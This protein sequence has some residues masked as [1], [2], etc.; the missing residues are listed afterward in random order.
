MGTKGEKTKHFI[1]EAAFRL[2]AEKGFKDVTM[3]DICEKTGLSRGGLYR[4]YD[5]TSQIFLELIHTLMADQQNEFEEK[6]KAKVPAREILLH[7]LDRYETEML[8]REHSLSIAIYEFF[9]GPSVSKSSNSIQQQYEA[10]KEMWTALIRYGIQTG[11][12]SP[13]SPE[14]VYD[15]IV[16]SYQGV[17][18]YNRLMEIEE[19]IPKHITSQ[20]KSLLLKER[21]KK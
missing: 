11:E 7:V 19:T 18:M 21:G 15:L 12:F 3:K 10:S 1:C 5:S 20:I 14:A 2:F 17:R 6:I 4:H 9:S 13:V 16:F 8:D